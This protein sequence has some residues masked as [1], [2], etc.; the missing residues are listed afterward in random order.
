MKHVREL[1]RHPLRSLIAPLSLV[2]RCD[3][4]FHAGRVVSVTGND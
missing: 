3:G 1:D 2:I 4:E